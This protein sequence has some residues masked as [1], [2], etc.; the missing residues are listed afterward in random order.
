MVPVCLRWGVFS[1]VNILCKAYCLI[2]FVTFYYLNSFHTRAILDVNIS[3]QLALR[4]LML[5]SSKKYRDWRFCN[6]YKCQ[7]NWCM[8]HTLSSSPIEALDCRN[9]TSHEVHKFLEMCYKQ[10]TF[11][12]SEHSTIHVYYVVLDFPIDSLL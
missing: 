9:T 5:C 2:N 10:W 11:S 8:S 3:K 4:Y 7:K 6:R 1:V 12:S